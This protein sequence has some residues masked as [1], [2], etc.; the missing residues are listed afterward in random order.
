MQDQGAK[1]FLVFDNQDRLITLDEQFEQKRP[2]IK[3]RI[4]GMNISEV[5]YGQ[6]S[7]P[8]SPLSDIRKSKLN[9]GYNLELLAGKANDTLNVIDLSSRIDNDQLTSI[10]KPKLLSK[11]PE[12]ASRN[13]LLNIELGG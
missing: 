7:M 10:G 5:L 4:I 13:S 12:D 3:E 9:L 2:G 11:H 6:A 8:K 1:S